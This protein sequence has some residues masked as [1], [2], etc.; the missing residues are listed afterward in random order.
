MAS[1]HTRSDSEPVARPKARTTEPASKMF[2]VWL[3][4]VAVMTLTV[5]ILS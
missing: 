4:G 5:M 2:A 1:P 3:F